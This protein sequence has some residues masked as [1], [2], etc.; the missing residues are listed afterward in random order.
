MAADILKRMRA[1][2]DWELHLTHFFERSSMAAGGISSPHVD[3][4]NGR[5]VLQHLALLMI[6]AGTVSA[7]EEIV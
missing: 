4:T 6:D 3:I 7:A 1:V 2:G 5:E